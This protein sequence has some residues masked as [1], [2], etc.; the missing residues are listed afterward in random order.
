MVLGGFSA[1]FGV[2]VGVAHP[3][4]RQ[5]KLRAS[6][7]YPPSEPSLAPRLGSTPLS[8]PLSH[9]VQRD[10]HAG[11][12]ASLARRQL[13]PVRGDQREEVVAALAVPLDVGGLAL[14]EAVIRGDDA[15]ALAGLVELWRAKRAAKL[16]RTRIKLAPILRKFCS[17]NAAIARTVSDR[18]AR[19]AHPNRAEIAQISRRN[20]AFAAP[21]ASQ[22]CSA[23]A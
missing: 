4:T 19:V 8:P 23:L 11:A 20:C 17:A 7:A 5:H 3:C 13:A 9:L 21:N 22:S 1:E 18:F 10:A 15:H 6:K 2:P 16:Q 14:W 12:A